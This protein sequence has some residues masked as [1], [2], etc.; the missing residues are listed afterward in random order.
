MI[1][2]IHTYIQSHTHTHTHM[3]PYL[4]WDIVG[5]QLVQHVASLSED[6]ALSC[7]SSSPTA[8]LGL[9]AEYGLQD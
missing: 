8:V 1:Q 2:Y 9:D 4:M 6:D 7:L 3:T 5:W